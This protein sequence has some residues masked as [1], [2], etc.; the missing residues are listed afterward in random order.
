MS[1]SLI[2]TSKRNCIMSFIKLE[3][4]KQLKHIRTK[5]SFLKKYHK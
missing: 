5:G 2:S 3:K 4:W 1:S